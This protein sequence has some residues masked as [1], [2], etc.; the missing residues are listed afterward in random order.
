[1]YKVY[2]DFKSN[3]DI[4]HSHFHRKNLMKILLAIFLIAFPIIVSSQDYSPN[5]FYDVTYRQLDNGMGVIL[6]SRGESKNVVVKLLVNVG[7]DDFPCGKQQTPHFLEHLL[8]TGTS[9]LSEYELERFLETRGGSSNAETGRFTT[10]YSVDIFNK[11]LPD[12]LNYLHDIMTDSVITPENIELSRSIIN[13]ENG[14]ASSA[15]KKYLYT[16][17]IGKNSS[18]K[19]LELLGINCPNIMTPDDVTRQD[20][21][22]AYDKYY[23]PN[24]MVFVI[25]GNF[26]ESEALSW[27]EKL[28]SHLPSTDLPKRIDKKPQKFIGPVELSGT[29][30]PIIASENG[31]G[32]DFIL[33]SLWSDDIYILRLLESYLDDLIYQRLRVETGYAYS[34]GAT[35]YEEED[36][37]LMEL[38]ADVEKENMGTALELIRQN[39]ESVRDG[40]I[41][42]EKFEEIKKG[43]LLSYAQGLET[44]EDYSNYY[45]RHERELRDTGKFR[46]EEELVSNATIDDVKRL[47]AKYLT[48]S[49]MI[50]YRNSPTLTHNQ[51]FLFIAWIIF[52]IAGVLIYLFIQRHKKTE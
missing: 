15:F 5:N 2:L 44:N 28:F 34:P 20:I 45:I 3:K 18:E 7:F 6:K 47:A 40:N 49:N 41:D 26:D 32:V 42:T 24:N 27:I 12:A 39:I 37:S 8:F 21:I 38:S 11:Y 29:L 51:F 14:G 50:I 52:L 30:S 10:V 33:P 16:K 9:K 31:V 22:D 17:D 23:K 4:A 43:L 25:V 1:M 13:Q 19:A 46:N 35:L 36:L 48:E